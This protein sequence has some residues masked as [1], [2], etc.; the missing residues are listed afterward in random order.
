[1]YMVCSITRP[2]ISSKGVDQVSSQPFSPETKPVRYRSQ[3]RALMKTIPAG[4][5][6]TSREKRR[7]SKALPIFTATSSTTAMVA[8]EVTIQPA[9]SR[10]ISPTARVKPRE[11]WG[12]PMASR[13]APAPRMMR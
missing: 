11:F 6:S 2:S 12:R 1:M 5:Q 3:T 8:R 10:R 7:F 9:Q 4:A 13:S